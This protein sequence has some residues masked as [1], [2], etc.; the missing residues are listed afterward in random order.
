MYI[1]INIHALTPKTQFY[2]KIRGRRQAAGACRAA[3]GSGI[4]DYLERAKA[5]ERRFY[6]GTGSGFNPWRMFRVFFLVLGIGL[7]SWY[8][9]TGT[10]PF[11][12]VKIIRVDGAGGEYSVSFIH[13]TWQGDTAFAG[14]FTV[15]GALPPDGEGLPSPESAGAARWET[16]RPF[17]DS[18]EA[19]LLRFEK[20]TVLICD[21]SAVLPRP[22]GTAPSR[23]REKLDMLVIPPADEK[24]IVLARDLFRPR[25]IAAAA[26]CAAPPGQNIIC[27]A[28]GEGGRFRY[29]FK[30]RAGKLRFVGEL[31]STGSGNGTNTVAEP[32][33]ATP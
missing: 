6:A 14:R 15:P 23:F 7:L 27:G 22:D 18:V 20:I 13:V 28:A 21:S 12:G 25:L 26:P 1:L 31:P 3:E 30:V 5:Y 17:A 11:G 4:I 19:V 2:P 24:G 33:E 10:N 32:V 8:G 9:K 29:D 16:V